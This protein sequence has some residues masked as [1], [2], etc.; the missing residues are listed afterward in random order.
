MPLSFVLGYDL[1]VHPYHLLLQGLL[2]VVIAYFFLRR[3]SKPDTSAPVRDV[4][5]FV[6][7]WTPEP[8]PTQL[9]ASQQ[10]NLKEV[11]I[12]EMGVTH[13]T[14]N[15][16][17]NVLHVSRCNFLGMS[18]NPKINKVAED[19]MRKYGVGSCGP[20][21]F[22]GSIDTHIFLEHRIAKFLG[23]E[24]AILYSSAFSTISSAIPAFA[25]RGDII[26]CDRGVTHSI[27]TGIVLSRSTVHYFKHNDVAD[28]ERI[29]IETMPSHPKKLVRKFVVVEGLYYNYGDLCPLREILAMKEK[30]KFRMFLDESH[31]IGVLGKTGRGLT[32]LL[33][34]DRKEIEVIT[35][36]LTNGF[37][38]GGGFC[39]GDKMSCYHQRL[40]GSGYVFSA[41][42]PPFLCACAEAAIDILE[43][44]PALLQALAARTQRF[45]TLWREFASRKTGADSGDLGLEITSQPESPVIHLRLTPSKQTGSR[46]GDEDK[47]EAICEHALEHGDVLVSRAKYIDG[48]RFLP[49]P[50]LRVCLNAAMEPRHVD[51]VVEALVRAVDEL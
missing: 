41:S 2:A 44:N 27:Q 46:E 48:E 15:G 10:R 40:N 17:E 47:L 12:S 42:L 26:I 11:V 3:S 51:S 7:E 14:V 38:A 29:L 6:A 19:A 20:R 34:V 1:L 50:S 32:E 25:K 16:K 13:A 33:G 36:Q 5:E 21:G 9:S 31:S 35:G 45:H 30:Y 28:L 22:Y 39:I 37:G 4:D 23:S 43:E 24:D 49:P 18:G 8:L